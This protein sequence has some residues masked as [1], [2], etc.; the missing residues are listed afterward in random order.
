MCY[1]QKKTVAVAVTKSRKRIK[2]SGTRVSK[3]KNLNEKSEISKHFINNVEREFSWN[4]LKKAPYLLIEENI[5]KL[6]Y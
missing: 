2:N 1:I 5:R 4:V 6:F 3:H